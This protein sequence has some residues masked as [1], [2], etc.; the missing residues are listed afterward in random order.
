MNSSTHYHQ[1]SFRD[2]AGRLFFREGELLRQVNLAGEA[3]FRAFVDSGLCADLQSRGGVIAHDEVGIDLAIEPAIAA[4]VIKPRLIPYLSWPYE[5][6]FQQLKDAALLTLD[7]QLYALKKDMTLKDASAYN[8][9]FHE[10]GPVLIDT[11]SF[12]R[13]EEGQPWPAYRQFCQHFLGPLALMSYVDPRMV[14]M[15]RDYID[16]IPLDLAVK[17]LPRKAFLRYG[18]LAHLYL[19]ARSQQKHS[20]DGRAGSGQAPSISRAALTALLSGLRSTV[21][22]LGAPA[23]ATEWENYYQDTNYSDPGMQHKLQVIGEILGRGERPI[24]VMDLGANTGRFSRLAAEYVDTVIAQ[25]IDHNAIDALYRQLRSEG[26]KQILPLVQDLANPSPG[27]GWAQSEREGLMQRGEVGLVMGLAL[28]HHLAI[29]N[30][31]P[32]PTVASFFA[33]LAPRAII[34]FV[35][36][37]DSQVDRMLATRED[38]FDDYT[39]DGFERAVAPF[40]NVIGRYPVE[41]SSRVIFDLERK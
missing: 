2:H 15:L 11:L 41:Q 35:P 17:L 21:A 20:D 3:D 32:L 37:G 27:I 30:N 23:V 7:I 12:A 13:Y 14:L 16:G 33:A 6:S 4:A 24:S 9:Q 40:F 38:I 28:I 29:G 19:H 22:K 39:L 31:L 1:S 36:K 34:E 8:V 5:W 25:D 10:G 26:G 18:L